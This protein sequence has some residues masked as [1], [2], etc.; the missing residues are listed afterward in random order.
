MW[1]EQPQQTIPKL[2]FFLFEIK[3]NQAICNNTSNTLKPK[4]LCLWFY[5][6]LICANVCNHGQDIWDTYEKH[7]QSFEWLSTLSHGREGGK[8]RGLRAMKFTKQYGV[9]VYELVTRTISSKV[10][11]GI[12]TR[13]KAGLTIEV[14]MAKISW[15]FGDHIYVIPLWLFQDWLNL[16]LILVQISLNTTPE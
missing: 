14:N 16:S 7:L 13:I 15:T 11:Q 12:L 1:Q 10:S 8:V 5:V 9:H 4:K 3:S 6:C 2:S